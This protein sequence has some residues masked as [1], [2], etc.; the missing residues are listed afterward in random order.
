MC[1]VFIFRRW[2]TLKDKKL[3]KKAKGEDPQILLEMF[4]VYNKVRLP[5]KT[6]N[7]QK[8]YKYHNTILTLNDTNYSFSLSRNSVKRT[9]TF[10]KSSQFFRE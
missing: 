10:K 5:I 3:R 2:Y 1:F 6:I 4:F 7:R 9:P 8:I